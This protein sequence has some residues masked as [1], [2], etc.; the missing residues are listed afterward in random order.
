MYNN[1]KNVELL[2][3]DMIREDNIPTKSHEFYRGRIK[4]F[5]TEHMSID[6]NHKRPLDAIT[7]YDVNDYLECIELSSSERLNTYYALKRF[8]LFTYRRKLTTNFMTDV[9]KPVVQKKAL[10]YIQKEHYEELNS[11]IFDREEDIFERLILGL[12]LFTGLSRKYI[13][14]IH[15][16]DFIYINGLYKLKVWKSKEEVILPIKAELQLIIHDFIKNNKNTTITRIIEVSEDHFS[17]VLKKLSKR[18]C[19]KEYSPTYFS[20]T[21]IRNSLKN[22]NYI[23]EISKLTLESI[24]TIEKHITNGIDTE[25][26]QL[27]ILNSF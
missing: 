16:D 4:K 21:F 25:L 14:N 1:Y 12:F 20:N 5:F 11:F 7:Y 27:S 19:S 24:S 2:I 10:K 18:A 23:W 6:V 26:K 3:E 13:Y 9:N 22:G 8:F 15:I 17:T